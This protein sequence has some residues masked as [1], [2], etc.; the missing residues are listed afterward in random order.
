MSILIHVLIWII[1]L[2]AL[3]VTSLILNLILLVL[4]SGNLKS[5]LFLRK[6]VPV[7]AGLPGEILLECVSGKVSALTFDTSLNK[8][9]ATPIYSGVLTWY[10]SPRPAA[11]VLSKARSQ[12]RIRSALFAT[13]FIPLLALCIWFTLFVHWW[14]IFFAAF[15]I[16]HQ[17]SPFYFWMYPAFHDMF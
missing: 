9:K 2:V 15:L 10:G 11:K 1:A 4:K 6:L 5:V 12:L 17:Y 13:V 8:E 3:G 7:L 16:F 14:G